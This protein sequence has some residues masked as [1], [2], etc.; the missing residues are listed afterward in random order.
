MSYLRRLTGII[1]NKYEKMGQGFW[2]PRLDG[3]ILFK[4]TLACFAQRTDRFSMDGH[5]HVFIDKFSTPEIEAEKYWT[6]GILSS[7]SITVCHE[8]SLILRNI[9]W[10]WIRV[11]RAVMPRVLS[12]VLWA[13]LK[14]SYTA[15]WAGFLTRKDKMWFRVGLPISNSSLGLQT[16]TFIWNV[17]EGWMDDRLW[18]SFTD[19][20]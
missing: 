8:P 7:S 17:E 20:Q 10:V 11:D 16:H 14:C 6:V 2:I 18:L 3:D 12:Q 15:G 5:C 19:F 4:W 13:T 1:Q 9:A